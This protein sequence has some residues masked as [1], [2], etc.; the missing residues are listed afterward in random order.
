[1]LGIWFFPY[2]QKKGR[3]LVQAEVSWRPC[4]RGTRGPGGKTPSPTPEASWPTPSACP[5]RHHPGTRTSSACW[6]GFTERNQTQHFNQFFRYYCQKVKLW[7][8]KE[9]SLLKQSF[10]HI[11]TSRHAVSWWKELQRQ[12]QNTTHSTDSLLADVALLNM[13]EV[14]LH[15][16]TIGDVLLQPLVPFAH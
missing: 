11:Y 9:R 6:R 5:Y 10:I 12:Y 13:N 14:T 15:K 1:M 8:F 7:T 4:C 3:L 16:Q 2:L